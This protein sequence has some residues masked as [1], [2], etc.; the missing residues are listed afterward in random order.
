MTNL[1]ILAFEG[2]S[3]RFVGTAQ[4]PEWV[5]ADVC[6][7][8]EIERTSDALRNFDNDE[9]GTVTI[10]TPGGEQVLLTVTEPGLYRLAFNSRKEVAKRFRRWVFHEVLPS[11]RQTGSYSIG[12]NTPALSLPS[13]RERLEAIELGINLFHKLGGCDPRT[14]LLFKDH[15]RN[16][17]LEEKFQPALPGRVEWPISD[18]AVV[19]GHRPS[20]AQ[21]RKIGKQAARLYQERHGEKP[22]QREQFV[23]GATRMVNVYGES[24]VDILDEAI[25]RVMFGSCTDART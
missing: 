6:E 2:H 22:V 3:V 12:T 17:V 9:K 21:L 1:S 24:D 7:I 4:K 19:L 20:P 15:I 18:R 25:A 5:A 10:R 13:V 14:E 23:D 8:L 16:I 11:V